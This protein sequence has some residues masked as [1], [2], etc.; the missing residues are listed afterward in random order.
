MHRTETDSRDVLHVPQG[1]VQV[2]KRR[3]THLVDAVYVGA[4]P[5]QYIHNRSVTMLSGCVEGR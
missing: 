3:S 2:R 4:R 1:R 5:H